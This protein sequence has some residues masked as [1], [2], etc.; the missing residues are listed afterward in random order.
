MTHVTCRLTAKYRDQLRNPTLGNRVWATV[1]YKLCWLFDDNL[2]SDC[3]CDVRGT[4]DGSVDC[5][6]N[7]QCRCK[8]HATGLR[9]SACPTGFFGLN[10][11]NTDGNDELLP[12]RT[13]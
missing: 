8:R 6:E 4:E 3:N 1:F 11:N 5:D 2:F 9:C 12:T 13:Q 10:A 7:G